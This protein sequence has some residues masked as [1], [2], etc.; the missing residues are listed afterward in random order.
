MFALRSLRILFTKR[1]AELISAAL[2]LTMALN[3]G[4]A[5]SR[6]TITNDEIMHI[7][8]GYYHLTGTFQFNNDHPPLA[9]MWS[10]LPLLILKPAI[11]PPPQTK[12]AE[13]Q[14]SVWGF[15]ARF[16]EANA[17]RF[18]RLA[19][20]PRVWMIHVAIAL[21]AVLFLFARSLFGPRA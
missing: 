18:G 11:P 5:A 21:G 19:F 15:H 17:E 8:A 7:P 14:E 4:A 13:I 2:L 6:K 3:L 10:A 12:E 1:P 20:W 9:K 16:W